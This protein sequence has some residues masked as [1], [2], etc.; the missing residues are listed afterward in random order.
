MIVYRI[1]LQFS[2]DQLSKQILWDHMRNM[3]KKMPRLHD[4][5]KIAIK[6]T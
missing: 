2:G 1:E 3:A 4:H 6:C 5:A